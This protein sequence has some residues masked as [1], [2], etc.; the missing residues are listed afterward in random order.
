MAQ[1]GTNHYSEIGDFQTR[2]EYSGSESLKA[3][4]LAEATV[5]GTEGTY[6]IMSSRQY[7]VFG[8]SVPCLKV[9][10]FLSC[11]EAY[12]TNCID[13]C[14]T[15]PTQEFPKEQLAPWYILASDF[16]VLN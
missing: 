14:C 3:S 10:L 9:R 15:S 4:C 8:F 13:Y 16:Q 5:M 2:C 7:D 11:L 6:C 1:C 12:F